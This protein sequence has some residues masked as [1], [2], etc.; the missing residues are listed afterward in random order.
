MSRQFKF[1]CLWLTSPL[2]ASENIPTACKFAWPLLCSAAMRSAWR[3]ATLIGF[4]E[5]P[6][7]AGRCGCIDP[8]I[9]C[10]LPVVL[11]LSVVND[12][13][14]SRLRLWPRQFL[15]LAV[16]MPNTISAQ[17]S[18][19]TDADIRASFFAKW[20]DALR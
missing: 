16:L 13:T 8:Q 6:K 9:Q 11:H 3:T 5:L 4:L 19:C 17:G 2:A 10:G 1:H 12:G 14:K 20:L 18:R 7:G 15:I